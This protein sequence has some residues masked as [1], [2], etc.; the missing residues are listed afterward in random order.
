[1]RQ[2]SAPVP[3]KP[4]GPIPALRHR[5]HGNDGHAHH[6]PLGGADVTANT[7][8]TA[9]FSVTLTSRAATLALSRAHMRQHP[10]A[11]P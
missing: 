4:G 9:G 6:E 3:G 5:G 7:G 11:A 8:R 1:M 10:S 2:P